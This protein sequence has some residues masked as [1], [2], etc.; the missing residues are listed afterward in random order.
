M[1]Y[2]SPLYESPPRY[3]SKP[4]TVRSAPK[5]DAASLVYKLLIHDSA[6]VSSMDLAYVVEALEVLTF[7]G[8][9]VKVAAGGTNVNHYCLSITNKDHQ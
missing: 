6:T 7:Y 1:F 5:N 9:A 2:E 3:P 4:L 8:K